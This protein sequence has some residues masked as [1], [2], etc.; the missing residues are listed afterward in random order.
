MRQQTCHRTDQEHRGTEESVTK[1]QVCSLLSVPRLHLEG[2]WYS[3]GTS[4]TG[5]DSSHWTL[6]CPLVVA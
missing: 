2:G 1:P 5:F 3:E 4:P 6:L